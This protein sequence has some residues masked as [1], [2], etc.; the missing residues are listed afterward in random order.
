MNR[1]TLILFTQLMKMNRMFL[2]TLACSFILTIS[3]ANAQITE[4]YTTDPGSPLNDNYNNGVSGPNPAT[5]G[6]FK[7]SFR[8]ASRALAND[9]FWWPNEDPF[10]ALLSANSGSSGTGRELDINKTNGNTFTF[11][12]LSLLNYSNAI[13]VSIKG[14]N[15]EGAEIYNSGN[16][17]LKYI[18]A[19]DITYTIY[20]P[21][22]PW[23]EI[24][25]LRIVAADPATIFNPLWD[26]FK[27]T[28]TSIPSV[29]TTAV[30]A[31]S[32]A[33]ATFGGIVTADGDAAVSARGV[34]YSSTNATPT[35][36]GIDVT[37]DANGLGTGSFS[38]SI[39]GLTP[40][41][42][43]YVRS[44]ATNT[45]GTNYGT[46]VSFTTSTVTGIQNIPS[47]EVRIYP[48]PANEIIY[49]KGAK[50]TVTIYSTDGRLMGSKQIAADG[51]ISVNSLTK[52]I[53]IIKIDGKEYKLIKK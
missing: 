18:S 50:G 41:T 11:Y 29:N 10:T 44:Y 36:G 42:K 25:E 47:G 5:Y 40:N 52:G 49:I 21:A 1:N 32:S 12:G 8:D 26:D 22:A 13:T 33:T 24:A 34:V 48:N 30:T 31:Y 16:I 7:Y 38:K 4:T 46:I 19:G 28:L 15:I 17:S 2:S 6:P 23:G 37:Q 27:Y 20:T 45:A 14:Y 9:I 39:S 35:I 53:Y 43:Y 51:S 3:V